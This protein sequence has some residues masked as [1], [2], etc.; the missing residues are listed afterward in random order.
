MLKYHEPISAF[1]M[2]TMK[3]KNTELSIN[4]KKLK[5]HNFADKRTVLRN[6]AKKD[7][8]GNT[9]Q[10]SMSEN[11]YDIRRI[12]KNKVQ[13]VKKETKVQPKK[14]NLSVPVNKSKMIPKRIYKRQDKQVTSNCDSKGPK[15]EAKFKSTLVT[16]NK[17]VAKMKQIRQKQ[18]KN[19]KL[20]KEVNIVSV[21][22]DS[23]T[24]G[25]SHNNPLNTSTSMFEWLIHP[26]KVE[27]FFK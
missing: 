1:A 18:N 24:T 9:K 25:E 3:R 12:S 6:G 19:K 13:N 8:Q 15:S 14:A 4:N 2:Y 7:I 16:L 27:D 21:C 26:I 22:K 23:K 10:T 11:I 17:G 20:V 5:K